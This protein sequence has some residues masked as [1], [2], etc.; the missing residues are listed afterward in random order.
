V[1]LY[2]GRKYIEEALDSVFAQTYDHYEI[3]VI[4]DGSTD[5]GTELVERRYRDPRLTV[6][7]RTHSGLNATRAASLAFGRGEYVAFLDQDDVW[8]PPKLERQIATAAAAPEAALV[9]CDCLVIDE[10]GRDQGRLSQRH[11]FNASRLRGLEGHLELLRRGCFVS[12]SS[13]LA[14][15]EAVAAA[16][17]FNPSFRY[18][19]D[20]DLW[21]RLSR[22][23]PI[24]FLKE[25]LAKYRLHPTQFTQRY[26][27]VALREQVAILEPLR[28]SNSYPA[29]V[30]LLIGD[31]LLGQHRVAVRAWCAQKRYVH[32]AH[33]ALGM[34]RYPDRIIDLLRHLVNLTLAGP[35]LEHAVDFGLRRRS[36]LTHVAAIVRHVHRRPI[37]LLR[38]LWQGARVMNAPVGLPAAQVWVDGSALAAAEVGHFNMTTELIRT[39]AER[40]FA[41]HVTA[42]ARGRAALARR[43]SCDHPSVRFHRLPPRWTGR[44]RRRAPMP[45]TTE[46]IIWQGRFRWRD[47]RR[48]A[49]VADLTTRIHPEFHTPSTIA[50]FD[51][52]LRYVQQRAHVIATISD[53]SRRDIVT[54]VAVA[55][56]SVAVLPHPV[57]PQY[58]TP[59]FDPGV[60]DSLKIPRKYVL[61]VGTIEPRKNLRRLVQAFQRLKAGA[62]AG[63]TLVLA[64]PPGWDP[65]FA[66][67][68]RE[69]AA[70]DV[71][72]PGYVPFEAL[73]SLYHFASAVAYPSVYEGLGLPVLEA[74]CCSAVV[75]ASNI[76]AMP[77][78]L[79]E[80][81][82]QFDPYDADD[83]AR[84]L[85]TSL[86]LDTAAEREHR[87]RN[88]A[89]AVAHIECVRAH[90]ILPG[91][92][93]PTVA[94]V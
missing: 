19:A 29:D 47:A 45:G 24:A 41:V 60:P 3:V 17:G 50:E 26:P 48:I 7:R 21:L 2:N 53:A 73:P 6:V 88:R 92:P 5:G 58:V 22:R 16:G 77:E 75:A 72:T 61:C 49:I 27:D 36:E 9:F 20:Y 42:N 63:H 68:L 1:C 78:V 54:H 74:M 84:A 56:D 66:D 38:S 25:P 32:A 90:P 15:R 10:N 57:H 85:H 51:R 34:L 87:T 71:M 31:N 11:P 91:L 55:P 46:V 30:R 18:A 76:S 13:A 80:A 94:S 14:R 81:G 59:M 12:F 86:T 89:R 39:L 67:F 43:M 40:G 70:S 64:G 35:L 79:G 93:A 44:P 28:R 37:R 8:L 33:A 65:T 82:I 4:D 69:T 83:I 23:H 62:A 52:F